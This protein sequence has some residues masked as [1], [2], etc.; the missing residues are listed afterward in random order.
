MPR[1]WTTNQSGG[2]KCVIFYICGYVYCSYC[3]LGLYSGQEI[4]PIIGYS[5]QSSFNT[6]TRDILHN[7]SMDAV[8]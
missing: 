1:C 4:L 5:V 7:H 8:T 3:H 2:F 6:A